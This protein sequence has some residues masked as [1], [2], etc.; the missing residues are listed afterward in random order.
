MAIFELAV[1]VLLL[2]K[3]L[4][5]PIVDPCLVRPMKRVLKWILRAVLGLSILASLFVFV[6][7]WRSTNDCDRKT[8]ALVHPMK[9]IRY[10]EYGPPDDVLKLEEVEKPVP[11]DD[12]ILVRVRAVSLRFFDGG[13]LEGG[14]GRWSLDFEAKKHLPGI[15]LRW[16]G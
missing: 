1:S 12:Q 3:G 2:I 14:V 7:Y 6:A 8:A 4:R 11:N 5:P 16:N 10:C 13:M 15:R 9:A